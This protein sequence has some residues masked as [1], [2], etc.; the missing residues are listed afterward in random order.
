VTANGKFHEALLTTD[1]DR[2]FETLVSRRRNRR[3]LAKGEVRRDLG[4]FVIEIAGINLRALTPESIAEL[5]SA[6]EFNVFQHTLR[7]AAS[8]VEEGAHPEEYRDQLKAEAEDIVDAWH[9]AVRAA[10]GDLGQLI[11]ESVGVGIETGFELMN[12]T[13]TVEL[14]AKG[15][16]G[17][18]KVV[19]KNANYVRSKRDSSQHYLS[20]VQR[21][22][23]ARL[24]LQFPLGL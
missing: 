16:I 22:E 17:V 12:A 9:G 11:S 20:Q 21:A 13:N 24:R 2:I 1:E 19:D 3:A 8:T 18:Y 7:R 10:R 23:T 6:K 14:V 15:L 5:Q 4:Q